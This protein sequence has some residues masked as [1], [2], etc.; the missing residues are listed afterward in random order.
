MTNKNEILEIEKLRNKI[1]SKK[2][3]Y[4]YSFIIHFILLFIHLFLYV[5]VMS[6]YYAYNND[7]S[8]NCFN[9]TF[10]YFLQCNYASSK[11]IETIQDNLL[12]INNMC[13]YEKKDYLKYN[14]DYFKIRL[15]FYNKN[16][17][18]YID[19]VIIFTKLFNS[20]ILK[21]QTKI[22]ITHYYFWGEWV[23]YVLF[24]IFTFTIIYKEWKNKKIKIN[25]FHICIV[26]F[27]NLNILYEQFINSIMNDS[28]HEKTLELL[29]YIYYLFIIINI[30]ESFSKFCKIFTFPTKIVIQT[31]KYNYI[32]IIFLFSFLILIVI[33]YFS[34]DEKFN[35]YFN[36]IYTFSDN[37][38]YKNEFIY[39]FFFI[40]IYN[41][42]FIP[43]I[44]IISTATTF[45]MIHKHHNI[46]NLKIRKSA[47]WIQLKR[48]LFFLNEKNNKI[49]SDDLE[50]EEAD[51]EDKKYIKKIEILKI[52][53]I[54]VF[55]I[56]LILFV[57]KIFLDRDSM[58][59]INA[60]YSQLL[61]EPFITKT[62]LE[63]SFDTFTYSSEHMDFLNSIVINN[64]M[65]NKKNLENK[66]LF[67]IQ[68]DLRGCDIFIYENFFHIFPYD[69][70][71]K[72][73]DGKIVSEEIA[74]DNPLI[75]NVSNINNGELEKYSSKFDN[76]N[77]MIKYYE[78]YSILYNFEYSIFL[79]I[80]ISFNIQNYGQF[81]KKKEIFVQQVQ[82]YDNKTSNSK[83]VIL[84]FL[85]II[86]ITYFILM[87][88]LLYYIKKRF[89]IWFFGFFFIICIFFFIFNFMI[90]KSVT[91]SYDYVDHIKNKNLSNT[92]NLRN[93]QN[94]KLLIFYL[95]RIKLCKFYGN[96]FS[97]IILVIAIL[98][99]YFFFFIN[100]FTS[101]I[102]Y[103]NHFILITIPIFLFVFLTSLLSSYTFFDFSTSFLKWIMLFYHIQTNKKFSPYEIFN[104]F[105]F[106][107]FVFYITSIFIFIFLKKNQ[108]TV[109][110]KKIHQNS[111]P[112][113][114]MIID[115]HDI[116]I[117]FKAV[118]FSID[119]TFEKVKIL[120]EKFR[121][122]Q[123]I[124]QEF[125]YY[126]QYCNHIIMQNVLYENQL[127]S[128]KFHDSNI[129]EPISHQII[130]FQNNPYQNIMNNQVIE[131]SYINNKT[132]D[133]QMI[134][135]QNINNNYMNDQNINNNYMNDQNINNNYM[136]DQ[137]INNNYMND[138]NINNNNIDNQNINNNNIDNQNINNNN[139]DNQNINNNYMNDHTIRN[140]I[141]IEKDMNTKMSID[142]YSND[143][144]KEEYALY[145]LNH[146]N[147]TKNNFIDNSLNYSEKEIILKVDNMHSFFTKHI[148]EK[149]DFSF[150]HDKKEKNNIVDFL[151]GGIYD[152][153]NIKKQKKKKKKKRIHLK[154]M[155]K[156]LCSDL[157]YIKKI[158]ISLTY[159]ILLK[160][161]KNILIQNLNN[162]N[163]IKKELKIEYQNKLLYKNH[164]FN[165]QQNLFK[166]IE[167]L[168]KR[169]LIMNELNN[170]MVRV[171]DDITFYKKQED[172]ADKNPKEISE[173]KGKSKGVFGIPI[174]QKKKEK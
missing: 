97:Y 28:I 82:E 91:Y 52:V 103:K 87:T 153:S 104:K 45:L 121:I 67:E 51:I 124:N 84:I 116:L 3:K 171:I 15:L 19:Y 174:L 77:E 66:R 13:N 11:D 83:L 41:L 155:L 160:I 112:F 47:L 115:D 126:N 40:L 25:V 14:T 73:S 85:L 164:L 68:S 129:K 149:Y 108:N 20:N 39:N 147:I 131:S 125:Q 42:F 89:F 138:Q 55:F 133:N 46:F 50:K 59:H 110:I 53:I 142:K 86:T 74:I 93:L 166:E 141:C 58:I 145:N 119:K 150:L 21:K 99:I 117:Y 163:S 49:M 172:R 101:F 109:K 143:T 29:M 95:L 151:K 78:S 32:L 61:E 105:I 12:N 123:I 136:N 139:I 6:I 94:F 161:K 23:F 127:N 156:N 31:I 169:V 63:K 88:F 165:L 54:F 122:N 57:I 81:K 159:I 100:Y 26:I 148:N 34:K 118:L 62:N 56:F 140:Q 9:Q 70:Y 137:Y 8:I 173:K 135:N 158:K 37:S 65:R 44:V 111:L 157:D 75:S 60:T 33:N 4:D 30:F 5:K 16:V 35:N 80:N 10:S 134:N 152:H 167:I 154:M 92:F 18:T 130:N 36:S 22:S 48:Y 146:N 120:K 7:Y 90:F 144:Q 102:K 1:L 132:I 107:F 168:E 113:D 114:N 69:L 72:L 162:L 79:L 106:F 43:M 98:K 38:K 170:G 76:N 96:L 17:N 64:I 71:I 24:N 27:I 128:L 2:V